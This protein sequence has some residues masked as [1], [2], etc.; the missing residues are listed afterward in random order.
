MFAQ[1]ALLALIDIYKKYLNDVK[2]KK[3]TLSSF[4]RTSNSYL[5]IK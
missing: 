1:G 2:K 3:K 5:T 4:E